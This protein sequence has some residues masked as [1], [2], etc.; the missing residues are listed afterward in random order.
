MSMRIMGIDP[1]LT[2]MGVG[3]IDERSGA[4]ACAHEETIITNARDPVGSRLHQVFDRLM[5][6]IELFGPQALAVERVFLKANSKTAVPSIQ[7]SGV[8]F[9]AAAK[10]GVPIHEYAPAQMKMAIAGTGTADKQQVRYMVRQLLGGKAGQ[11]TPDSADAL[12]LAI[13][14]INSSRMQSLVELAQ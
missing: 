14:H 13:C 1:G 8:A 3:I 12:A 7:A 10:H 4:I 5:E 11:D 9:L 6:I 2:R